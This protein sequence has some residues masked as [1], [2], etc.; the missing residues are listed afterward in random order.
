MDPEEQ[1]LHQL[2]E[3]FRN[4]Q[5]VISKDATLRPPVIFQPNE[6][7]DA[8]QV[9]QETDPELKKLDRRR[10][11]RLLDPVRSGVQER[12]QVL[13][14]S[15]DQEM[16]E[17]VNQLKSL[18]LNKAELATVAQSMPFLDRIR[19]DPVRFMTL[20]NQAAVQS[21]AQ[22]YSPTLEYE[23]WQNSTRA[24]FISQDSQ[25]PQSSRY[26]QDS[27]AFGRP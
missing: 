14:V 16:D 11:G 20:L 25:Y 5:P 24:P 12:A 9:S 17:M 21:P 2:V 27:T 3:Q 15:I 10:E 19:M 7:A 18:R 26:P 1:S 4:Q 23:D 6:T 22:G 13:P 8:R